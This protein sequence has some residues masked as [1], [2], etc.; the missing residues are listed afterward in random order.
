[1][2][3]DQAKSRRQAPSFKLEIARDNH[4]K[5]NF[6]EKIHHVRE[7]LMQKVKMSATNGSILEAALD[8][9]LQNHQPRGAEVNPHVVLNKTDT[10]QDMYIVAR[11]SLTKFMELVADHARYCPKSLRI[12]KAHYK[13]HVVLCKLS[14]CT[15]QGK[16]AYWWSSSPQIT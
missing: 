1:M 16:H 7:I 6:M 5:T 2:E 9:W 15:G 8:F 14:C 12:T 10:K 13:G 4:Y 3:M 11:S